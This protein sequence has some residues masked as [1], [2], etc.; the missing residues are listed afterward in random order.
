LLREILARWG[1]APR[2]VY[3]CGSNA[4]VGSVTGDLVLEAIPAGRIRAERYGGTGA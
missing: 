4:F 1:Q 3:V 2:H